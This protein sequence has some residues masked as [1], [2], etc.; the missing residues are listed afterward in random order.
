MKPL[1][2]NLYTHPPP[3]ENQKEMTKEQRLKEAK[4]P[5]LSPSSADFSTKFDDLKGKVQEISK[6]SSTQNFN[7]L[8]SRADDC[9]AEGENLDP[10]NKSK[11]DSEEKKKAGKPAPDFAGLGVRDRNFMCKPTC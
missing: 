7:D 3:L 9:G 10:K 11:I 6:P 5:D 4:K 1:P 8:A 2:L